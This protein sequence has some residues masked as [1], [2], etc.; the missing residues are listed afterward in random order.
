VHQANNLA[1]SDEE[2]EDAHKTEA[3]PAAAAAAD[4]T[5]RRGPRV[6]N[7][8]KGGLKGAGHVT[9]QQNSNS[10][11]AQH[12]AATAA[13]DSLD[14]IPADDAAA[15]P[16]TSK[17]SKPPRRH[18]SKPSATPE[19]T[20]AAAAEED[21]SAAVAPALANGLHVDDALNAAKH[22]VQ[23]LWVPTRKPMPGGRGRP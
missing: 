3:A 5:K 8:G 11:I 20:A 10:H 15:A 12:S 22:A 2:E 1:Q 16:G 7:R 23:E 9:S 17:R 21:G 14:P 19:A 18:G 13:Q 4:G 6:R